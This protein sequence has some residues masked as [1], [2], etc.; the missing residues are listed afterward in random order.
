MP[1]RRRPLARR[2]LRIER[3]IANQKRLGVAGLADGPRARFR[4]ETKPAPAAVRAR[5]AVDDEPEPRAGQGSA[6]WRRRD[7]IACFAA[8]ESGRATR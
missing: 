3:S 2:A 8:G 5:C 7:A 4:G 1:R 6:S